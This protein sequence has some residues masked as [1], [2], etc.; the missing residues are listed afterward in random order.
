[1]SR[2]GYHDIDDGWEL[3]KWR[4]MVAS[5]IRGKRGQKL[6]RDLLTALDTMP[7]KLL[8]AEE[9]EDQYG[10]HC[11]LGVLGKSRGFDLASIDPEDYSQVATAFGIAECLA[12]EIVYMN[13]EY[14]A[15][16]E[17][18]EQRWTRMRAWVAAQIKPDPPGVEP[19]RDS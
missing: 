4:G 6:L 1:M 12:Q 8:I 3:I 19:Y 2:S 14:R 11:A 9:L 15:R 5:A 7:E 13:D 16:G 17:T 10:D 18:P